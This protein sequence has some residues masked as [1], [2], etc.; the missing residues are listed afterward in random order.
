MFAAAH[1]GVLQKIDKGFALIA[2]FVAAR[3]EVKH[4]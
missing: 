2:L 3:G 4:Q 1:N